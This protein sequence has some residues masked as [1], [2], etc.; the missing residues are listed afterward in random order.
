[1]WFDLPSQ[2]ARAMRIR[3]NQLKKS[4]LTMSIIA[5]SLLAFFLLEH[6]SL[7]LGVIPGFPA[8]KPAAAPQKFT[9]TDKCPSSNTTRKIDQ[10]IPVPEWL[11]GTW[12]AHEQVLLASMNLQT[13]ESLPALPQKIQINRI[14]KIGTQ[15]DRKGGI[16]HAG[17]PYQRTIYAGTFTEIQ[18]IESISLIESLP[19]A[20][21]VK[22]TASVIRIANEDK[23]IIDK[24]KEETLT[25]YTPVRSDIVLSD[26]TIKDTEIDGRARFLTRAMRAEKRIEPYQISDCDERGNLRKMFSTYLLLSGQEHLIP[27]G[28]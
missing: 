11:A 19:N 1:M 6:V 23:A 5:A 7:A 12:Q 8:S 17:A 24:F 27:S 3:A 26:L 21:I 2:K 25:A 14:S 28:Q 4:S 9:L 13:G 22:T 16:W 18:N 20:L 10:W 15:T